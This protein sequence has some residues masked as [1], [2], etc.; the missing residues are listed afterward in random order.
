MA[1]K[2]EVRELSHMQELLFEAPMYAIFKQPGRKLNKDTDLEAFCTGCGRETLFKT[3][4]RPDFNHWGT[5]P[6]VAFVNVTCRSVRVTAHI[7]HFQLRF[8]NDTISKVGQF[9]SYADME[10]G[11]TKQLRKLLD[12]TSS[13]ELYRAIGLAAAGV[14]IGSFVY[15]RR[16]FERILRRRFDE[17]KAANNWTEDNW[18]GI[19]TDERIALL[20]DHLPPFMVKNAKLYSI[21][22]VGIHELDEQDC[23]NFFD[24][25]RASIVAILEQEQQMKEQRFALSEAEKA[26]QQYKVP[27]ST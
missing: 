19:R 13:T 5:T 14:G 20:K 22:S 1:V 16:I 12:R 26:I 27:T 3:E 23:L 11:G 25:A 10:N 7:A 21:L 6:H 17:E 4:W 15:I 9:P 24:I 18:K 8:E 2:K